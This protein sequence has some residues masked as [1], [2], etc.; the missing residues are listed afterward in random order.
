[1]VID[2]PQYLV[3]GGWA[4][5]ARP[6]RG[7][8]NS[9]E[10]QL[11]PWPIGRKFL[12]VRQDSRDWLFQ[13]GTAGV[14]AL[15][16]RLVIAFDTQNGMA[17]VFWPGAGIA[18]GAVL[19]GGKRYAGA[20]FAGAVAGE[21][22]SGRSLP[23]AVC[24][25]A[26]GAGE[27]LLARWLLLRTG[28]RPFDVALQSSR[29]FYRLCLLAAVLGP[30]FG[31]AVG[32]LSLRYLG[33][34][35]DS[36]AWMLV[37]H[38]W[39]GDAL[40]VLICTPLVLAFRHAGLP[41]TRKL[42]EAT[43]LF[44]LALLVG[45]IVFLDWFGGLL[46]PLR[47][48][49]WV[50]LIVSV[51]AVRL[52]LRGVLVILVMTLLQAMAGI[53]AG[54]G[55]F[56]DDLARAQLVNFWTYM[57]VLSVVGMSLALVFAERELIS[58]QL[59]GTRQRYASL[60]D[61]MLDGLAHFRM[62]FHD[63]TP[64]DYEFFS[65]NPAFERV[66]GLSNVVGRRM[67]DLLPGYAT[68]H[69]DSLDILGRVA[70]TGEPQ[71]W[72]R[73][74]APT[75]RWFANA[76]Y[77]AAPGEVILMVENVSERVRVGEQLRKLSLAVE[78]SPTSIIITDM[79]GRIEYVNPAFTSVSGYSG[80]EV[81]GQNP[82][83]LQS[84]RTPRETYTDLWATISAGKVW[85]GHF[86]NRRKDGT[87]YYESATISALNLEGG[88]VSH[89]VAVKE[90]VTELRQAMDGLR[91][92]EARLRLALDAAGLCLFDAAVHEGTLE[93]SWDRGLRELWGLAPGDAADFPAF[94]AG[95]HPDDRV[96]VQQAIDR[97]LDPAGDGQ[98]G[99]EYRV[100]SRRDGAVRPVS[101]TGKALFEESTAV[102][103]L[104]VV[105]DVSEQKRLQKEARER[106]NEME[107]LLNQQVAA[108]TAAAIAHELNQP[109]VAVSA[110]SEAAAAMLA[111][112]ARQPEKLS[113]ALQG[114]VEQA[115]RAGRTLHELLEF[116]HKGETLREPVDLNAV[117]R[118][119]VA[120][121]EE[122][123][124]GTL[125]TTVDLEANLPSVQANSL[126]IQKVLVNLLE[127]STEAMREAGISPSRVH[128]TVRTEARASLARVT[129]QD[130]GPGLTP[131][132][133]ERI[134][135]PFFTTKPKGVGL[136]LAISRALV[137]AHGGQLWAEA[138]TGPGA[139]FH[140]TLPFAT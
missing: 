127:N 99:A 110:Y 118:S 35:A 82:R 103:L 33:S 97:A 28:K 17:G 109:L 58:A 34:I 94:L 87:E 89:Y 71:R 80:A 61:N 135:E 128:V 42:A 114:A 73:Y 9:A 50:Y 121:A 26:A 108:H 46:G 49:Y 117:V 125:Q 13:A 102:R 38:W 74:F 84:G 20:V 23:L 51:A 40:G 92:S 6:E 91:L 59:L 107:M 3:Y 86:A 106:R 11:P 100:V 124:Y 31:A 16:A 88:R 12:A 120:I 21:L 2:A 66:T 111:S 78:Q 90:D 123:S 54:K 60:F 104:G 76:A 53:F 101:A 140:F 32:T 63:G 132:L 137:E 131:D 105:K 10:L 122:K 129:V 95:V 7:I 15:L 130:S 8:C 24:L 79:N 119:A 93:L 116:L 47:G 55:T 14:Y 68:A 81:L 69:Q 70:R 48:S 62:I 96:A 25:A 83:L 30:V 39:M 85:R 18:L 29:D 133:A 4:H 75:D 57:T 98:Y 64:V 45:Q 136:G 115:Q 65:A 126:Q 113:R 139:T 44:A 112:G 43:L 72:T 56:G 1:M 22:W 67:S 5:G 52:G 77:A 27:A 134:F 37:S 138:S 19:L 36:H 41:P